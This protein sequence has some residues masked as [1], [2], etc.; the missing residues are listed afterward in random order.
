MSTLSSTSAR[1]IADDILTK[2]LNKAPSINYDASRRQYSIVFNFAI[3]FDRTV[4]IRQ[5]SWHVLVPNRQSG[6]RGRFALDARSEP[7]QPYTY[8]LAVGK[9]AGVGF[10]IKRAQVRIAV[11]DDPNMPFAHGLGDFDA[12]WN[13]I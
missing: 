1:A 4:R 10:H 7:G 12:I 11:D 13:R 2:H 9:G 5:V 3:Y 6:R 8:A